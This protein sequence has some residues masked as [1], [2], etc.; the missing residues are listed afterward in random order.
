MR[1]AR[2]LG[3]ALFACIAG[4][5]GNVVFVED[6]ETAAPAPPLSPLCQAAIDAIDWSACS[7]LSYDPAAAAGTYCENQS[8]VPACRATSEVYYACVR[9]VGGVCVPVVNEEAGAESGQVDLTPCQAEFDAFSA[10]LTECGAPSVCPTSTDECECAAPSLLEGTACCW[11]P[12]CPTDGSVPSCYEICG[13][14][15]APR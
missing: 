15:A 5:G 7:V 12:S 2:W 10:C 4:C 9:D 8:S 13:S 14:C 1:I 11:Y 6:T 3:P